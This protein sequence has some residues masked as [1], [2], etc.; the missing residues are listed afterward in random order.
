MSA[1]SDRHGLLLDTFQ[2][3]FGAAP[4]VWVRAPGRVDLLGSHT[5]YNLGHVLTLPIGCDTWMA[6]RPQRS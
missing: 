5:D 4:S 3:N 1:K 6:I 2:Q